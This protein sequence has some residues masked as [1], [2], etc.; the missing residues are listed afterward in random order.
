MVQAADVSDIHSGCWVE[1]KCRKDKSAPQG[2]EGRGSG[3][4]DGEEDQGYTLEV[5]M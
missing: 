1:T 4:G 3:T 5:T 2:D